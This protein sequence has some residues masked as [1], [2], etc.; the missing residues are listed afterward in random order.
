M[1]KEEID[2]SIIGSA[3]NKNVIHG[4]TPRYKNKP[5]NEL[6]KKNVDKYFENGQPN[7]YDNQFKSN[8]ERTKSD[9][10]DT[11]NL[12]KKPMRKTKNNLLIGMK[13]DNKGE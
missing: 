12:G 13:K 8:T 11:K 10:F 1:S 3:T 5:R 9:W 4:T 7:W 6:E 2:N